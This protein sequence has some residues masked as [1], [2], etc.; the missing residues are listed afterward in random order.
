MTDHVCPICGEPLGEIRLPHP[1]DPNRD[2]ITD[3]YACEKC[4]RHYH[5]IE[6][7][8]DGPR[9]PDSV[10]RMVLEPV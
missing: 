6:Y 8:D 3:E 7:L 4:D 5:L 10:S 2:V 1:D 9:G